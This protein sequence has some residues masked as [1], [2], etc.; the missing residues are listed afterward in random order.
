MNNAKQKYIL[1][2]L[3]IFL[4]SIFILVIRIVIEKYE[5]H[6]KYA[7]IKTVCLVWNNKIE[8]DLGKTRGFGDKICGL[9]Y[10]YRYF[11]SRN[12][13]IEIVVDA[14]NDI[15]G[16]ILK[17]VKSKFSNIVNDVK[18]NYNNGNFDNLEI[19]NNDTIFTVSYG[20][21][22]GELSEDEKHIAKFI[23]EPN[24]TIRKEIENKLLTL[25][26]N[27]TIKH[28]RFNDD[29]FTKDVDINDPTFNTY[30]DFLKRDYLETDVLV[31]NSKNFIKY[32]VDNLNIKY[33][34][35]NNNICDVGHIGNST[36]YTSV[37]NSYIEYNIISKSKK[38]MSY[39]W[40]KNPS[41]FVLWTSKI[42]NIPFNSVELGNNYPV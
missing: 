37:K 27:F 2:L 24:D 23:S 8:K 1:F 26:K 25:P 17:N 9:M 38:I 39:T 41:Y 32:A 14:T 15:C 42:Y 36:D 30:F 3:F 11:K 35:C 33:I 22:S 10:T 20:Y 21:M 6:T 34:D 40:Y 28:F 31:T 12:E 18:I 7:N 16:D 19:Y 5:E 29:V 13:K 4:F